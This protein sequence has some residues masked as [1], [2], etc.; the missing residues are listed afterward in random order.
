MIIL[1]VLVLALAHHAQA[2]RDG[3]L[4]D[5][6]DGTDQQGLRLFPDRLGKERLKRYDER[7]QFGRQCRHNEDS[8][9]K[10]VF[11]LRGLPFLFKDQNGQSRAKGQ[12]E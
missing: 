11:S 2:S 10:D 7:P 4:A 1:K 12:H 9:G 5:S 8:R 3:A 6:K